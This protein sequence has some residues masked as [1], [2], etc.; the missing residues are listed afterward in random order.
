MLEPD[1]INDITDLRYLVWSH[2][3]RSSGT[4][5]SYLKA[6][7]T[8]GERKLYYKLS[9]FDDAHGITGHE[10]VNEIIVDRLLNCLGIEHLHYQLIHALIMIDEKE[11]ETYVCVSEDF[12]EKGDSKIALDDYYDLEHAPGE[13]RMD[14]V[15]RMGFADYIYKM[16]I[17]DYLI[18]NR[19]RHG[20]NIEMLFDAKN[21][22]VRPAPLFDHGLSLLFSMRNREE[23][24]DFDVLSDLP[25]QSYVGGRSAYEN[26]MIIPKDER[27]DFRR[28]EERDREVIMDGLGDALPEGFCDRIWEMIWSRWCVY[29]SL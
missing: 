21:N 11:Y 26:L 23:A 1:V 25:V 6:Y 10:C 28:L 3:R 4:A 14:F 5:G 18:L 16:L 24:A 12:K 2:T 15:R 20:A 8:R 17:T 13:S 9:C 19:D 29:E 27:P 22:I 7:E